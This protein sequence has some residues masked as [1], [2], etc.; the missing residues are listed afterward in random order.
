M[1]RKILRQIAFPSPIQIQLQADVRSAVFL[2][3]LLC[4]ASPPLSN[5]LIFLLEFASLHAR[6]FQFAR[7]P[8]QLLCPLAQQNAPLFKLG[9]TTPTL[10]QNR[11]QKNCPRLGRF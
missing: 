5:R 1:C 8:E 7:I 2:E 9:K 4:A 10:R 3:F 11:Q 6:R